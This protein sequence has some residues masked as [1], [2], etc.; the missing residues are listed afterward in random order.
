MSRTAVRQAADNWAGLPAGDGPQRP[1]LA[2]LALVVLMHG[3]IWVALQSAGGLAPPLP[4]PL[5]VSLLQ[6]TDAAL[7][8]PSVT[9]FKSMAAKPASRV[10]QRQD[11]Q[12]LA[13][14]ISQAAA[15][16][17]VARSE[18]VTPAALAPT[19]ALPNAP[20]AAVPTAA[21]GT[22]EIAAPAQ[23]AVRF[24]AAYLDNPAP[25]YS[26][27]S[28]RAHEEG[29]VVLHVFVEASGLPTKLEVQSSSGADRL[30]RSA[31]AA[32]ARWKFVPARQGLVAVAAW[33]LVPIVFSLKD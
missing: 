18:K 33:V 30:D 31:L 27:L 12:V 26:P 24:D 3:A 11:T 25:I 28:R 9:P 16:V 13:S 6:P 4:M 10:A 21:P 19:V 1:S 5:V 22:A 20:A 15:A 8:K 23:T 32:V 7:A 17:E 29:R 2:V 14:E